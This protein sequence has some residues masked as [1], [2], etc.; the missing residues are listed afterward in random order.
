MACPQVSKGIAA[1]WRARRDAQNDAATAQSPPHNAPEYPFSR[2]K[3]AYMTLFMH[4]SA[5]LDA[6]DLRLLAALQEDGAATNAALAETLGLSASQMSRR[7]HRL[8]QEGVITRYRAVIAPAAIGLSVTAFIHVSLSAHSRD[9]ARRFRDLVRLTPGVLEAHALTG[10]ADY[11]LKVVA[12][13][14][15]ELSSLINEALLPHDSVARVRSEIVLE[16]LKAEAA[17]PLPRAAGD[18]NA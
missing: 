15:R 7:R 6:L 9:N 8:E 11:L 16:T 4:R 10:A 18:G 12:A 5:M 13:D 14:L 2:K 17:L 1:S 3:N